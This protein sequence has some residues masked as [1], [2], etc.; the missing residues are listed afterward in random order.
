MKQLKNNILEQW[1]NVEFT[2]VAYKMGLIN[3]DRVVSYDETLIY[4]SIRCLNYESIMVTSPIL[5]LLLV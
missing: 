2:S 1:L 5:L 3:A 4:K